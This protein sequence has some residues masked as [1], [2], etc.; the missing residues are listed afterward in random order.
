M[1]LVEVYARIS[2]GCSSGRLI[3]AAAAGRQYWIAGRAHLDDGAVRGS[4]QREALAWRCSSHYVGV[5]TD[6]A[7]AYSERCVHKGWALEVSG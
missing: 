3:T 1:D 7:S 4:R 6:G 5:S 2:I